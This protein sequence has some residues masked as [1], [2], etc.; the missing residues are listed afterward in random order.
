MPDIILIV[1]A[2]IVIAAIVASICN[3]FDFVISELLDIKESHDRIIVKTQY[4]LDQHNRLIDYLKD[5]A[6][7][8]SDKLESEKRFKQ[9]TFNLL[10][11]LSPESKWE[12]LSP[13]EGSRLSMFSVNGYAIF[14]DDKRVGIVSEDGNEVSQVLQIYSSSKAQ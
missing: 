10:A 3:D 13:I 14:R 12:V 8:N 4:L 2:T 7:G 11:T 5:N 6:M 1:A 9:E